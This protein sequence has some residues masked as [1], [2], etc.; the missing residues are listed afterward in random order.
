MDWIRKERQN[1]RNIDE[2]GMGQKTRRREMETN[3]YIATLS[4]GK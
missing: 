2:Q 3:V 4:D 1:G